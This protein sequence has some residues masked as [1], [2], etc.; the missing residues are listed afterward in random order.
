MGLKR[1]NSSKL[2]SRPF[3]PASLLLLF[4]SPDRFKTCPYISLMTSTALWP[5]KPK[6]LTIAARTGVSR[7]RLGT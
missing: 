6:A 7:A 5:P 3:G 1:S 2:L 4:F